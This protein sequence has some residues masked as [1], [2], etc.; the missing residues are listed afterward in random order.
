[1]DVMMMYDG[2]NT[3]SE[4]VP[5]SLESCQNLQITEPTHK[6]APPLVC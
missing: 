1:M 6:P 3:F 4:F 5:F 2:N